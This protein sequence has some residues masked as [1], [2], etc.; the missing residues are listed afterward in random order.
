MKVLTL[1]IKQKYFDEIVAGTKTHECRDVTPL[2]SKKYIRYVCDGKEYVNDADLPQ[3][4]EVDVVP[5]K[6]DAIK[7]LTGAYS[8]KRPYIIVEVIDAAIVILTDEND[9]CITYEYEGKEYMM[10]QMDYT[11]GKILEK[12]EGV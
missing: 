2:N 11:L 6:Y 8:G 4:G 9:N 7:L 5:V 10:A 1:S 3:E 12:S